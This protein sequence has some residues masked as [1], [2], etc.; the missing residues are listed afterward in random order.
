MAGTE[1]MTGIS[2]GAPTDKLVFYDASGKVKISTSA[3]KKAKRQT[4]KA[5]E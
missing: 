3:M 2:V 5:K 1:R 4:A